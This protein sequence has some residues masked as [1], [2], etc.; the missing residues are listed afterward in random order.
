MHSYPTE[1][2]F[3]FPL[4]CEIHEQICRKWRAENSVPVHILAEDMDG[5]ALAVAS[6]Y[7]LRI[8]QFGNV[9]GR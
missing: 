8:G 2:P 9:T 3:I 7:V 1:Y 5:L 6:W 4:T